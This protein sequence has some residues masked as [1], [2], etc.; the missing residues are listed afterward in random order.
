MALRAQVKGAGE[1]IHGGFTCDRCR[2]R[3]VGYSITPL[4]MCAPCA[5]RVL[6]DERFPRRPDTRRLV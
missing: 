6:L 5:L 3:F 4:G 2:R 1:G